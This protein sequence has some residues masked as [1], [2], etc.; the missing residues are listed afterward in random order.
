[1][2]ALSLAFY[3]S[4]RGRLRDLAEL[5]RKLGGARHVILLVIKKQASFYL[6]G[7]LKD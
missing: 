1:L 2:L 7:H 5:L 6:P 3:V 4:V